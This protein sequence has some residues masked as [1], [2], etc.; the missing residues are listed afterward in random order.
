MKIII[1]KF[2][3]TS[4]GSLNRIKK[5]CKIIIS[6]IKKNYKVVVV[7]SAMSGVTNDLIKKSNQISNNIKIIS[8]KDVMRN[9]FKKYKTIYIEGGGRTISYFMEKNILD[10]IHVCLCP[11]MLGGGRPSFIENKNISINNLKS[12]DPKH[13]QM[14]NDVLFDLKV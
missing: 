13:Y 14:G 6:Y 8:D 9:K 12:Y 5:V 7:S 3:G 10:R 1:L 11:I 4:V 2:G